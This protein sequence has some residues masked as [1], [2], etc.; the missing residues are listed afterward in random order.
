MGYDKTDKNHLVHNSSGQAAAMF[1]KVMT[2]AM[3]NVPRASFIQTAP[4]EPEK[5]TEAP[6]QVTGLKAEYD[7]ASK[8]VKLSW[9]TVAGVGLTYRVYRKESGEPDFTRLFELADGSVEDLSAAPGLSYQYYVAAYNVEADLEGTPSAAVA[10]DVPPEQL[11]PTEP[12]TPAEPSGEGTNEGNNGDGTNGNDSGN[13][14]IGNGKGDG[15][16][17]GSDNSTSNQNGNSPTESSGNTGTGDGSTPNAGT[18]DAV[19][20]GSSKSASS[21]G[22]NGSSDPIVP[23]IVIPAP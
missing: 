20:N 19:G 21:N 6:A 17:N 4:Q 8:S 7:Q 22:S 1:G 3:K 2:A 18:A 10:L 15:S 13:M 9:N 23:D 14:W 11:E 5:T 12:V 16:G